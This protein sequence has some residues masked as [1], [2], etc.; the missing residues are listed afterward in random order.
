MKL[1]FLLFRIVARAIAM[2]PF[3]L[4]YVLSDVLAFNL[5]K[6]L[7]Y[8]KK[9][10]R[11]NLR[12]AFPGKSQH[13]LNKIE[14]E[15]YRNLADV[16]LEVIKLRTIS[17]KTLKKRF[18]FENSG[19]LLSSLDKNKSVLVSIG[20]CGNWEWM[21]T[22][23]GLVLGYKGYALTKPLTDSLFNDYLDHIR[24]R[25]NPDSTIPFKNGFRVMV[26]RRETATFYV[27]AADQTP[28]RDEATY[29]TNFLNQDTPFFQGVE[30]IAKSLDFDVVFIDI[31]RVGRGRYN[32]VVQKITDN[33]GS[34]AEEEI[35]QAYIRHLEDAIEAAPSN[36][37]WS[38]RRWKHS[39]GPAEE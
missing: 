30:K 16:F 39:R 9:V 36:W 27:V 34:T 2:L 7:G 1:T 4:I 12:K 5:R 26:K 33:P 20:H 24:H 19:A 28:T 21:G 22:T 29:W 17:A 35:T 32:G 3:P 8:R 10:V 14:K 15:Y 23:L 37:L 6:I 18:T 13:E 31:Q 38:H 11:A 25:L